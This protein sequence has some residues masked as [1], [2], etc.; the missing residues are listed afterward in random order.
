MDP[1]GESS[2]LHF[3]LKWN[4]TTFDTENA[5]TE[6]F[7]LVTWTLFML[8]TERCKW[9]YANGIMNDWKMKKLKTDGYIKLSSWSIL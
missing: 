6:G 5:S 1:D 4:C 8:I 9:Y 3:E 2:R 7:M